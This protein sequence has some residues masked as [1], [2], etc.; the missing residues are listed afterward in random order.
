MAKK[1]EIFIFLIIF[2]AVIG[3]L[4]S[5][6]LSML[7]LRG[8]TGAACD[9]GG[10]NCDAVL[11]S[12]YSRLFGIPLAYWGLA[13]YSALFFLA[14]VYLDLKNRKI[15]HLIELWL[16]S[17]FAVSLILF[18]LQAFVLKAFCIYCLISEAAVFAMILGYLIIKFIPK[19]SDKL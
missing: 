16:W 1:Q 5:G 11:T 15:L 18:Y 10:F 19:E 4:D 6:Y 7:E 2:G 9:L 14:I 13:Y 12:R 3:L 17:G 8:Q